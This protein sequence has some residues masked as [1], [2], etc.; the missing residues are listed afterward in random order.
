MDPHIDE[1]ACIVERLLLIG[2]AT[3]LRI[4]AELSSKPQITDLQG[5]ASSTA[6]RTI[7]HSILT[8]HS[9]PT[10]LLQITAEPRSSSE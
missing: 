6:A 10:D 7:V 8:R 1:S 5:H 2:C 9:L 3:V 4:V